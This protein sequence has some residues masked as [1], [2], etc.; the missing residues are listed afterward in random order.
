MVTTPVKLQ[1]TV[2][3][4]STQELLGRAENRDGKEED[5]VREVVGISGT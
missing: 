4:A 5:V 2:S 1:V 3:E